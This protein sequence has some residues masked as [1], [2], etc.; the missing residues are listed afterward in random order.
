[1]NDAIYI[2]TD[3]YT[4]A[5]IGLAVVVAIAVAYTEGRVREG[6]RVAR[7]FEGVRDGREARRG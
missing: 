6:K 7:I 5:A 2:V 3:A 1:M 4:L